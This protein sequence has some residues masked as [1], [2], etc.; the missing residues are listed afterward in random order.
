MEN[1]LMAVIHSVMTAF[2]APQ[3]KCYLKQILE[4]VY[5]IH[6]QGVL[7]RD[8]K[9]ANLLLN[10]KG[11]LKIC[12]FG[13]AVERVRKSAGTNN[14][15]TLWYRAPE[16][17]LGSTFYGFEID[18]WSIGCIFYELLTRKVLFPGNNT[19]EQM[20]NI[21]KLC[22]TPSE[23]NFPGIKDLPEYSSLSSFP[24][25][26]R[27]LRELFERESLTKEEI[28]ILDKCLTLDPD[29]RPTIQTLLDSDYLWNDPEPLK[30]E[31]L[32]KYNP[33]HEFE[34][35]KNMPTYGRNKRNFAATEL[36]TQPYSQ[37]K[38][39]KPSDN[40]H[41][42]LLPSS[43]Q[44]FP[45]QPLDFKKALVNQKQ[46]K[47]VPIPRQLNANQPPQQSNHFKPQYNPQQAPHYN[48][49]LQKNH[50]P[51]PQQVPLQNGNSNMQ[52]TQPPV[53]PQNNNYKNKPQPN[54][55][56]LNPNLQALP[57]ANGHPQQNGHQRL[58]TT[59]N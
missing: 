7:H 37:N 15:V 33:V 17:L 39:F 22:G 48:Q 53:H 5:Y 59:V 38:R 12:D 57:Q 8:L 24:K 52:H 14:V 18:V 35:K 31:E 46:Q 47:N 41:L 43:H 45:P 28:D 3:V 21:F 26:E 51:Y 34:A 20:E 55:R 49:N 29:S 25:Y 58:G 32:P 16:L 44:Q 30:L 9:G 19:K 4:G 13:H 36:Q 11:E 42:P 10:H 54:N 56:S 2:S 50:P 27:K 1:D 23:K 6:T 40:I